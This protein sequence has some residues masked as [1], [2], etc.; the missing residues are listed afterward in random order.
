MI[1]PSARATDFAMASGPLIFPFDD[2][3]S[4][5]T[6]AG[7]Q[8]YIDPT[9]EITL[10]FQVPMDQSVI[11]GLGDFEIFVNGVEKAG[12]FIGWTGPATLT[13]G[14]TGAG[15]GVGPFDINWPTASNLLRSLDQRVAPPFR[16]DG[17]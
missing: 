11:P 17:L 7:I 9:L 16:I 15:W 14:A 2:E 4:E 10:T 5:W 3:T 12:D 8:S 6:P 13:I 1:L